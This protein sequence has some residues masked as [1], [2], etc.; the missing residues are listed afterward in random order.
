MSSSAKPKT[1]LEFIMMNPEKDKLCSSM[2][3][4]PSKLPICNDD[5]VRNFKILESSPSTVLLS[6]DNVSNRLTPSFYH[7]I[8]GNIF[9]GEE[10]TLFGLSG[11][12]S[13]ASGII[14]SKSVF[15]SFKSEKVSTPSFNDILT[16][17]PSAM[18]NEKGRVELA[19]YA[20]VPPVLIEALVMDELTP[21]IVLGKSIELLETSRD[22]IDLIFRD[23]I[24]SDLKKEEADQDQPLSDEE[25]ESQISDKKIEE[26]YDLSFSTFFTFLWSTCVPTLIE[27]FPPTFGPLL[28][29]PSILCRVK[30]LHSNCLFKVV[31]SA[32][33]SFSIEKIQ[34]IIEATTAAV[35]KTIDLSQK[36][37]HLP[38]VSSE[39]EDS[40]KYKAFANLDDTRKNL[41]LNL[42][43]DGVTIPSSPCSTCLEI[44]N[45]KSGPSVA[46]Y[47]N[48]LFIDEDFA[49]SK[50]MCHNLG[51]GHVFSPTPFEIKN[52]SPFYVH[53]RSLSI[54]NNVDQEE[55]F[56]I[57]M[58]NRSNS[59]S[60]SDTSEIVKND[61]Y[62]ATD[63]HTLKQQ[64]KNHSLIWRTFTGEDSYLNLGLT[65][66][67]SHLDNNADA[68]REQIASNSDFIPSFL[69]DVHFRMQ[70]FFKSCFRSQSIDQIR[71]EFV[72]FDSIIKSID[73]RNYNV[74][75][76]VWYKSLIAGKE[77]SSSSGSKRISTNVDTQQ[78]VKKTLEENPTLD[79]ACK[80]NNGETFGALFNRHALENLPVL[81]KI[82]GTHL[83]LKYH[84]LGKCFSTCSRRCTHVNLGNE[85]LIELRRFVQEAR[86]NSM[87]TTNAPVKDP[88][89]PHVVRAK[90]LGNQSVNQ[91]LDS[92]LSSQGETK[93]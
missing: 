25:I 92:G 77:R 73:M 15:S 66:I 76:P 38:L 47:L 62:I 8:A 9:A 40:K 31:E 54:A 59:L 65:E 55:L 28:Q 80:L 39:K 56:V 85:K 30:E 49:V 35:M 32:E 27:K 21:A 14:F 20:I 46:S 53:I 84:V 11:F 34:S 63:F 61:L 52:V 71:F 93:V 7:S 37:V 43:S 4:L 45:N 51:H 69:Q 88:R 13:E 3:D 89:K 70:N 74:N 86:A 42:H 41:I 44:L 1:W 64:L 12:G 68:Y 83:C 79:N 5:P 82:Q 24:K 36:E 2:P 19:R 58:L 22:S 67:N 18:G 6:F 87:P 10:I 81:P 16:L 57:E 91:A 50:G 26:L 33:S 75:P 78:R 48:N 72:N 60:R 17:G 23:I 29:K 90:N